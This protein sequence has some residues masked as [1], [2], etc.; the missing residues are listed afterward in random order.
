MTVFVMATFP[1]M[2]ILGIV[3]GCLS[4]KLLL[5]LVLPV[6][7]GE[8]T[9]PIVLFWSFL[10]VA[11]GVLAG[12]LPWY[13]GFNWFW[14]EVDFRFFTGAFPWTENAWIAMTAPIW[15]GIFWTLKLQRVSG[16][17]A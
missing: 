11:I 14:T 16:E 2:L 15:F 17:R 4:T 3:S 7:P 12:M 6:E 8:Y 9:A 5:S 10:S 1:L 13:F